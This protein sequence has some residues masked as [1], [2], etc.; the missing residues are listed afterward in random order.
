MIQELQIARVEQAV[1]FLE[2]SAEGYTHTQSINWLIDQVGT[3]CQA[4]AFINGQQAVAK[5]LLNKAKVRA[6]EKMVRQ[7]GEQKY[8]SPSLAKD[9]VNSLCDDEQYNYD[10]CERA[11]RTIVHTLDTLRTCISALKEEM[12]TINY[13]NS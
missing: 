9:Y 11:T 8:F 12:K 3:L 2:S 5:K 10:I 1:Q 13:H 4:L 6:Y 7:Y